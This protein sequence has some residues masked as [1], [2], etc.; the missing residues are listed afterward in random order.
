MPV[1]RK[2]FRLKVFDAFSGPQ[3][4]DDLEL[5]AMQLRGNKR[6]YRLA[7]DFGLRISK[8]SRRA[9]VPACYGAGE[10]LA[11]NRV[12]GVL[13]NGRQSL[14][15]ALCGFTIAAVAKCQNYAAHRI[16]RFTNR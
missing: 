10:I 13:N 15:R 4:A 3:N 8:N 12:I 2:A 9:F 16:V 7:N 14:Y 6:K 11:N 1:L 5:L